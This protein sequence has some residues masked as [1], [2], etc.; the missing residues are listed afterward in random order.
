MSLK[1][2]PVVAHKRCT[3]LGVL[4]SPEMPPEDSRPGVTPRPSASSSSL[5]SL[6]LSDTIIDNLKY[7]PSWELLHISAE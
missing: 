5:S 4:L 7:E 3:N 6:E 1:Y 2:E